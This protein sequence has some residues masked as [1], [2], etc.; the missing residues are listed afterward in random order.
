M[1]AATPIDDNNSWMWFRY[2]T[3]RTNS[4][5]IQKF[6]SWISVQAE[7]RIVQ[8]QD[9]R[10]FKEMVPG[11]IDAVSHHLVGADRGIALYKGRR[12]Q[13]LAEAHMKEAV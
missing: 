10:I 12:R 13:L 4:K 3:A 7:R 2:Y 11:T 1:V 6:F 8:P 9:W 5:H